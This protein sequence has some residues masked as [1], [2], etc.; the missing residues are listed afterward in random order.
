MNKQFKTEKETHNIPTSI[1]VVDSPSSLYSVC[2]ET[3]KEFFVKE[4]YDTEEK[5]ENFL[6]NEDWDYDSNYIEAIANFYCLGWNY[7]NEEASDKGNDYF[8]IYEESDNES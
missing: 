4:G 1:N 5:W 6:D 8:V 2:Y 7:I 3:F